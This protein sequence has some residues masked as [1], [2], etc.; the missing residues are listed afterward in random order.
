MNDELNT[1]PVDETIDDAYDPEIASILSG[2]ESEVTETETTDTAE[3]D[4][5]LDSAS[6][7]DPGDAAAPPEESS[8]G[9]ETD[10]GE[11]PPSEP[12]RF[13][14]VSYGDASGRFSQ[15]DAD[16][17]GAAIGLTG[18]QLVSVIADGHRMQE[19]SAAIDVLQDYAAANHQELSAF[20]GSLQNELLNM[21]KS[22]IFEQLQQKWPNS[23]A[24]LLDQMAQDQAEKQIADAR[25][26]RSS[27]VQAAQ[28]QKQQREFDAAAARW[29]EV[30]NRFLDIRRHEDVPKEVYDACNAGADPVEAMYQYKLDAAEKQVAELQRLLDIEKKNNSNRVQSP[31]SMSGADAGNTHENEI[32][33][34]LLS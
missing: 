4:S 6:A 10:A 21:Q 23:D 14:N 13:L 30:G 27:S 3:T 28:E 15:A 33:N 19:Y 18:E 34:I 9:E 20:V 16:R 1:N 24:A 31:G 26:A 12:E 29:T 22:V 17:L 7:D 32:H 2:S 8:G 11:T 5:A 25:S